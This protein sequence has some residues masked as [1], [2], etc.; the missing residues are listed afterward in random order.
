MNEIIERV[1][2]YVVYDEDPFSVF[3]LFYYVVLTDVVEEFAD[4][5]SCTQFLVLDFYQVSFKH[6]IWNRSQ[7]RKSSSFK[8]LPGYI[9]EAT[10]SHALNFKCL[11]KYPYLSWSHTT[12]T[13]SIIKR[14]VSTSLIIPL[15]SSQK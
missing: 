13:T 11:M 10:S 8:L 3:L 6:C 2:F 1:I 12:H 14:S 9:A 15:F 5:N 7:I 4:S